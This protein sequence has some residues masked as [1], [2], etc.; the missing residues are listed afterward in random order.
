[1]RLSPSL[2]ACSLALWRLCAFFSPVFVF[3]GGV[4][5][6]KRATVERRRQRRTNQETNYKQQAKRILVAQLRQL[7]GDFTW[8]SGAAN[9]QF[10]RPKS[11]SL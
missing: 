1:M 3:D 9:D 4:P 11:A 10:P 8:R 6:L 2:W 5:V 7:A